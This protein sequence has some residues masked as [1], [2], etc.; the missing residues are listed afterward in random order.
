MTNNQSLEDDVEKLAERAKFGSDQELQILKTRVQQLESQLGQQQPQG[1]FNFNYNQGKSFLF[2]AQNILADTEKKAMQQA[3]YLKQAEQ[4]LWQAH[5]LD[6]THVECTLDLCECKEGLIYMI[7]ESQPENRTALA[8]KA[9]YNRAIEVN[10]ENARAHHKMASMCH[11]IAQDHA[12][13]SYHYTRSIQL[14]P[15]NS[16]YHKNYG[17]FLDADSKRD[18]ALVEYQTAKRLNPSDDEVDALIGLIKGGRF[19]DDL[20]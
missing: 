12:G 5:L 20:R 4:F 6:T 10:E 18:A 3:E 9:L 1:D 19:L 2:L 8:L 17:L 13:A 14:D 7:G 11:L 16:K 15:N